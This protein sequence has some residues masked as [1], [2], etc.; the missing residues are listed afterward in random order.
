MRSIIVVFIGVNMT[1]KDINTL[2]RL[3]RKLGRSICD[4]GTF[5]ERQTKHLIIKWKYKGS[6]FTHKFPGTTKSI[7]LNYQYSQLRKNLRA[8]GLGPP[9]K[10]TK[11]PIG[12]DEQE[13]LLRE[14][15]VYLGT[16]DEGETPYGG[17]VV[18]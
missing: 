12:S 14:L 9:D 10:G 3:S 2:I 15:W 18:K 7:S 6:T 11:R 13:E 5:E 1:E 4:E 16:D 8:S 17:D